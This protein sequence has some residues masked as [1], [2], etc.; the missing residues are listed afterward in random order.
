MS[1]AA[2]NSRLPTLQATLQI[3]GYVFD[4]TGAAQVPATANQAAVQTCMCSPSSLSIFKATLADCPSNPAVSSNLNPVIS[5]CSSAGTGAGVGTGTG[6]GTGAGVGTGVASP[7]ELN[8]QQGLQSLNGCGV[9]IDAA[10]NVKLTASDAQTANCLCTQKNLVVYKMVKSSCEAEISPTSAQGLPIAKSL[11]A[12]CESGTSLNGAGT[13]SS[14]GSSAGSAGV[15]PAPGA[16]A[17]SK[18][19]G[20]VRFGAMGMFFACVLLM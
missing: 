13:G 1:V 11:I 8:V 12:A 5:L 4:A 17:P 7:C 18:G 2:C 19:S 20:A 9:T 16:A 10:G 14:T 3:C 6:V 15:T